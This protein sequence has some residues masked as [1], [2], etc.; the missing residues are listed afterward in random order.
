MV[1][2]RQINGGGVLSA[3]F[4]PK[5]SP[6]RGACGSIF[7]IGIKIRSTTFTAE[8]N[9]LEGKGGGEMS[10]LGF[11]IG[12]VDPSTLI[13]LGHHQPPSQCSHFIF[14]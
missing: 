12:W 2:A 3:I 14:K 7:E 9:F 11:W 13:V 8:A 10:L 6:S 5:S 1:A 4:G